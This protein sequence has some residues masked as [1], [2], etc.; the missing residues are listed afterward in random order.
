MSNAVTRLFTTWVTGVDGVDHA[1]TDE[2]MASGVRASTG[3]FHAVC[4]GN[5]VSALLETPPGAP[6]RICRAV[7]RA[8]RQALGQSSTRPA[9][10][11]AVTTTTTVPAATVAT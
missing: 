3:R 6:C 10:I 8:A 1:V 11:S 5:V 9:T 2:M 4:G 7:L